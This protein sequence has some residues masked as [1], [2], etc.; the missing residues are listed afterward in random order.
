MKAY[1]SDI[2]SSCLSKVEFFLFLSIGGT[3]TGAAVAMCVCAFSQK[4]SNSSH[5]SYCVCSLSR[6]IP[7][8]LREPSQTN[9]QTNKK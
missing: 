7:P 5:V 9:K 1:D 4:Y 2:L 8:L 3:L 6:C